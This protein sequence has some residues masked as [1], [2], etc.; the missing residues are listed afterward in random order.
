MRLFIQIPCH[1]EADS[2]PEVVASLPRRIP[3]IKEIFLVV[4]DDGS[5]DATLDVARELGVDYIVRNPRNLGLAR[6]FNKGIETC[7]H[8]GADIIVNI[9][10]DNQHRGEDIPALVAPIIQR[11]AD[12]VVGARNFQDRVN[13]GVLK[14]FLEKFG[15]HILSKLAKTNVPDATC[16]LRAMDRAAA[17]NALTVNHFSYT[18]EMIIQ[19]GQ[20]GLRVDS[21]PI[22]L[23]PPTRESRLFKSKRSFI[24]RQMAV[25][26]GTYILWAPRSF[27]F[28]LA[29][30]CF[31][32]SLFASARIGYYLFF[33]DPS[34]IKFR[35]GTG[36]L[37][38]VSAT[39]AL[40]FFM[41]GLLGSLFSGLRSLC[42]DI[43]NRVRNMELH[44]RTPP[45]NCD[46]VEAASF[47]QWQHSVRGE[48]KSA[49]ATDS[50]SHVN[51]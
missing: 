31:L 17:I 28:G 33:A 37:L 27:F 50:S 19:A 21:V 43:R 22:G 1:N 34:M 38:Y 40:L 47:F 29:L 2:L 51:R 49:D 4:M 20:S 16:G 5:T 11:Q 45:L 6:T 24:G 30:F 14:R 13:F 39:S 36:L 3:G 26:L 10:G 42:M 12:M 41:A 8:Y 32:V 44:G 18:L 7:L 25:M 23:N 48:Y 15:S 9:D 35:A 46:I